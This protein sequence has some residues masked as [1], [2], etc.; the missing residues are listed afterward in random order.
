METISLAKSITVLTK[1]PV[2][3]GKYSPLFEPLRAQ[4]S[5]ARRDLDWTKRKH[6]R[7]REIKQLLC[8]CGANFRR[9]INRCCWQLV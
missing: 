9:R 7:D 2:V 4:Q 3:Q 8:L 6:Q 1:L 5:L